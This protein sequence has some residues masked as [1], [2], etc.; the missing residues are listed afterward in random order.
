MNAAAAPVSRKAMQL[1][2]SL[3]L[4]EEPDGGA[5]VIDDRTLTASRL[6]KAASL[7]LHALQQP[8]TQEDLVTLLAGAADCS[9]QEAAAPVTKLVTE[10]RGLGWIEYC[11][12]AADTAGPAMPQGQA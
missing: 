4:Q 12:N 5:V 9:I 8:R 3:H 2:A 7:L 11:R 6:N 1:I 10:L